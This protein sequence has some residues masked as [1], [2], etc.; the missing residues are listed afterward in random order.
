MATPHVAGVAMLM[1]SVNPSLTQEDARTILRSTADAIDCD[2]GC[3]TGQI[4]A[5]AAVASAAG[6]TATGL[7]ATGARVGRG[8]TTATVSFKNRGASAVDVTFSVGGANRDAVTLD[9]SS[10]TIP[11]GGR[12]SVTATIARNA[13]ASDKG[14]ALVSGSSDAGE[15]E[16][17]LDWTSDA[18]AAVDNVTVGAVRIKDNGDFT[19]AQLVTTN[20]LGGYQYALDDL[21]EGEYLI[22]GLLDADNNGN[23]DDPT[24]GTGFYVAPAP[25]GSACSAG[26]CGHIELALGDVYEGADFLVAPG[27]SGGDDVGG[28]GDGATGAP[29]ASNADCG[30]GLY[31]EAGFAG[32]YCTTDCHDVT[33]CPAGTTCFAITGTGDQVC[34]LDCATDGDC[35]RDGYVCDVV[36]GVGSCIPAG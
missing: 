18:A 23:F 14:S 12:V 32:G 19:V 28:G 34:F 20:R 26:G 9:P 27:F 17:R 1:K 5:F 31:C 21:D 10:A 29:C 8:V 24:D 4:N 13:D 2:V 15:A 16:A 36:A 25:D 30:S 11:A 6:D 22:V 33:A 35:G 7:T 3:G